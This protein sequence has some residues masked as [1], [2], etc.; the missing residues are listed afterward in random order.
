MESSDLQTMIILVV[1]T[2]CA[3][4]AFCFFHWSNRRK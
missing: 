2:V 1:M 4:V 3:T